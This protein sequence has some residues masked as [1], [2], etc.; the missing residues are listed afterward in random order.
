MMKHHFVHS[1]SIEQENSNEK[2]RR[3]IQRKKISTCSIRNFSRPPDGQ[4]KNVSF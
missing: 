3:R 4:L 2:I 1:K